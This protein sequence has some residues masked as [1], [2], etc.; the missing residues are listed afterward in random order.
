MLLMMAG[1]AGFATQ[2]ISINYYHSTFSRTD[3]I[4]HWLWYRHLKN[5]I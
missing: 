5:V 3:K 2:Y 1:F 4:L